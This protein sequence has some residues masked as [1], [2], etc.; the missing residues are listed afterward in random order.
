MLW[1]QTKA[2]NVPCG[3]EAVKRPGFA[4]TLFIVQPFA[5]KAW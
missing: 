4:E 5:L 3:L 1:I 2:R